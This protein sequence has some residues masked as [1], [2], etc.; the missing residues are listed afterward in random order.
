[1]SALSS[2]SVWGPL[3]CDS[4]G[5]SQPLPTLSFRADEKHV[6]VQ[7]CL[8]AASKQN[9]VHKVPRWRRR[10]LHN[11]TW[12]GDADARVTT[13]KHFFNVHIPTGDNQLHI[14]ICTQQHA[15]VDQ[16]RLCFN[17]VCMFETSVFL[18]SQTGSTPTIKGHFH[19]TA[20]KK[21]SPTTWRRPFLI[22]FSRWWLAG[23]GSPGGPKGEGLREGPCKSSVKEANARRATPLV[24][25]KKHV[26]HIWNTRYLRLR[27]DEERSETL[28][29]SLLD[30]S[31]RSSFHHQRKVHNRPTN[32]TWQSQGELSGHWAAT[33]FYRIF[34]EEARLSRQNPHHRRRFKTFCSSICALWT[35]IRAQKRTTFISGWVPTSERKRPSLKTAKA[36]PTLLPECVDHL[37]A[38]QGREAFSFSPISSSRKRQ[39][40]W[41]QILQYHMCFL[42]CGVVG[43]FLTRVFLFSCPGWCGSGKG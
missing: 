15:F 43:V 29:R 5:A 34:R 4:W 18:H 37:W 21:M 7:M 10:R 22:R 26:L 25:S 32:K 38:A 42:W 40:D 1:M 20:W 8:G 35:P 24:S 6:V 27:V 23:G 3:A 9:T 2:G 39:M 36:D 31:L 12:R 14:N 33:G 16:I 13:E 41:F 11:N 17:D 19:K 30:N 28:Q